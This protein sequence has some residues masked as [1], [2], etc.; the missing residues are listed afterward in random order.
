MRCSSCVVYLCVTQDKWTCTN[1]NTTNCAIG[2]F[3]DFCWTLRPDWLKSKSQGIELSCSSLLTATATSIALINS[4]DCSAVVT[5][6]LNLPTNSATVTADC[7]NVLTDR[8]TVVTDNLNVASYRLASLTHFTDSY[9]TAT[10][11][12]YGSGM[13]ATIAEYESG[14]TATIAECESGKETVHAQQSLSVESQ[15][16]CGL[17]VI[18][19][20]APKD[21]SIVHGSTGHQAC[22]LH[23]AKQLKSRRQPCPVCRRPIH[24]V[25]RNYYV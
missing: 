3:C 10:T 18:C 25:I 2:R 13:T 8:L 20:A 1:C 7:S 4:T 16:N 21:A 9:K 5:D 12:E 11:A 19:L 23:C 15:P 22:C 6:G 14:M 17:C 24:R